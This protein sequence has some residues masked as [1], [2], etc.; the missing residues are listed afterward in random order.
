MHMYVYLRGR[1]A[2][3]GFTL[4]GSLARNVIS[5]DE[6]SAF[7]KKQAPDLAKNVA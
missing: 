3:A 1:T 4:V 2:V 7:A 6:L 5:C